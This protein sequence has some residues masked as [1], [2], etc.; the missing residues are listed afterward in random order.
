MV[1]VIRNHRQYV[2]LNIWDDYGFNFLFTPVY[3]SSQ[4]KNRMELWS[5]LSII[6][7]NVND[8]WIVGGD[9]N[10]I[11]YK[12]EKCGGARKAIGCKKFGAWMKD[13]A[14][15]DMGFVGSKFTWKRG[16]VYERLDRFVCNKS[17]R[18]RVQKFQVSHLPRIQSVTLLFCWPLTVW[19]SL[20][21]SK[22]PFVF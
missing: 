1:R 15:E 3:G 14:M 20:I 11:L 19:F 21:G 13:C 16:T 5:E 12:E 4:A 2:H 22:S 9:F 18:N 7:P 8:P 10:A 6:A 17:W